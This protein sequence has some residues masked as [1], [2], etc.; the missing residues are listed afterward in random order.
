MWF[1]KKAE[2]PI[3][4]DPPRTVG[5][6]AP[7]MS[8]MRELMNAFLV[9]TPQATIAPESWFGTLTTSIPETPEQ[10]KKREQETSEVD[11][12]IETMGPD[13]KIQTEALIKEEIREMLLMGGNRQRILELLRAGK[14]PRII[15]KKEGRRDPLFLQWG[16]GIADSIEEMRILG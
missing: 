8:I 6:D 3:A 2:K 4:L 5:L 14:T 10:V 16:D 13:I 11:A 9:R 12:F 15:R 1:R 7:T